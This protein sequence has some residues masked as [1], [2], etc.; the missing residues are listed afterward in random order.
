MADDLP[1]ALRV[2]A[3]G[4]DRGVGLVGPI[5]RAPDRGGDLFDGGGRL[6]QGGGLLLGAPRQVVGGLGDLAGSRHHRVGIVD[7]E[8][9]RRVHLFHGA[10]EVV[11]EL[12]VGWRQILADAEGEVPVRKPGE[13]GP[14]DIDR[15]LLGPFVR[16]PGRFRLDPR[17]F[18]HF[19]V[20]GD[21][22]VHV[23]QRGLDQAA[24]GLGEFIGLPL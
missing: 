4:R 23:E 20:G 17:R 7:D 16:G 9:H 15:S 11:L 14:D 18:A 5:G 21:G 10:V 3:G 6:F 12:A 13:T 1:A 24:E 22:D 19:E 2:A 8:L